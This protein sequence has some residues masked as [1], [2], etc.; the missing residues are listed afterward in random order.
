MCLPSPTT[1]GCA[2][3]RSSAPRARNWKSCATATARAFPERPVAEEEA[4][5]GKLY[6]VLAEIG[7]EKLVGSAPEMAPGTFWPELTK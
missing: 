1:S 5:A 6:G 3:R 4:D 2:S 7:G